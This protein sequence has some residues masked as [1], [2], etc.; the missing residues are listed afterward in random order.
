MELHKCNYLLF[1]RSKVAKLVIG[2][3]N[4]GNKFETHWRYCVV[5]LS[6]TRL[7]TSAQYQL[8][9]EGLENLPSHGSTLEVGKMSSIT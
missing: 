9:S 6:K 3:E 2:L 7:K 1:E 4:D 5:S 8:N